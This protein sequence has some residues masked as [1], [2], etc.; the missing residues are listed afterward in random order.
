MV[1]DKSNILVTGGAGYIGSHTILSLLEQGYKV[2]SLDNFSNGSIESLSRIQLLTGKSVKNYDVDVTDEVSVSKIFKENSFDAI[3]HFAGFKA[4]GQSILDPL[5]Y[6]H[7]NVIGSL[8]LIKQAIENKIKKFVFSSSATVYGHEA[9]PPYQET[10]PK[11]TTSN[12]YGASKSMI[13][14]ILEDLSVANPSLNI[15]ILRYFNPIGAHSSGVIGE[16]PLGFPDNLMPYILQVAVGKIDEL[17]IFGGDYDTPDGTCRRD[18]L[19]VMDLA[20]GHV[21]A[22]SKSN[23]SGCSIYNLGTGVPL[24]VL[25]IVKAFESVTGI[26][27]P[28]KIVNRRDGDLDEFWADP[29]KANVELEWQASRSLEVMIRDAWNWKMKNPSGYN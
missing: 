11:G 25:E 24:S 23:N 13:E 17:S 18:Y 5:S 12:P 28:Y 2:C 15:D 3:I 7:N 1:K 14:Q 20:E 9:V 4:V 27:I 10:I 19:H 6:Y 21:S 16:D 22:L 8:V 26:E 29:T